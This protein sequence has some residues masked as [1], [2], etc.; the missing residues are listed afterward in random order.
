[1]VGCFILVVG[2][3]VLRILWGQGLVVWNACTLN[4]NA[5][6][7]NET[8]GGLSNTSPRKSCDKDSLGF[9]S[10][11]FSYEEIAP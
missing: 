4:V 10:G 2:S 6:S 7:S 8:Q 1:M 5:L 11:Y 9:V 3:I